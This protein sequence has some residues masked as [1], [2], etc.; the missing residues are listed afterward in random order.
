MGEKATAERTIYE[1][2]IQ[3]PGVDRPGVFAWQV[4]ISLAVPEELKPGDTLAVDIRSEAKVVAQ[5][6][7]SEPSGASGVLMLS[8]APA[9]LLSFEFTTDAAGS[10]YLRLWQSQRYPT[11]DAKMRMVLRSSK[12]SREGGTASAR[13]NE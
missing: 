4:P 2:S 1:E 8:P 3:V 7:R 5:L 13:Y 12:P 10:F 9:A 6:Y 11:V